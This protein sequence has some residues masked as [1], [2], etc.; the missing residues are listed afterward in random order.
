[1]TNRTI[2]RASLLGA[3]L[4]SVV[5]CIL[6]Y[7]FRSDAPRMSDVIV[8]L[9]CRVN[10]D[11]SVSPMLRSRVDKGV[12]LFR[13]GV[14]PRILFSGGAVTSPESES[15]VM[16]RYAQSLGVPASAVLE[17]SQARSTQENARFVSDI[18]NARQW[19]QAVIVTSTFH[20]PRTRSLFR[21]GHDAFRFVGA[22]LP[23]GISLYESLTLYLSELHKWEK[24]YAVTGQSSQFIE[25]LEL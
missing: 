16:S 11:G 6:V 13:A 8:V 7:L 25:S 15:S 4:A 3:L 21:S 5:V 23:V 24:V 14:A 18:M 1:M 22:P 10:S 12:E 19:H 17:E 20:L 9:G 2:A